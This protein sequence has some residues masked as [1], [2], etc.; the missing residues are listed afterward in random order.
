MDVY[1]IH[2]CTSVNVYTMCHGTW[3]M[4][5]IEVFRERSW[6]SMDTPCFMIAGECQRNVS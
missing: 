2:S 5:T 6:R 1:D 3:A 4:D